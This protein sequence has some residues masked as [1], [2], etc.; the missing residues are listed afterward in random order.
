MEAVFLTGYFIDFW[1]FMICARRLLYKIGHLSAWKQGW[2]VRKYRRDGG[3]EAEI[4]GLMEINAYICSPFWEL[5]SP[6]RM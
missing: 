5:N 2:R 1:V 6:K 4:F 3:V